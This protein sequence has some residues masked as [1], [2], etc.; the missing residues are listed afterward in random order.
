MRRTAW[1]SAGKAAVREDPIDEWLKE[2]QQP[3]DLHDLLKQITKAVLGRCA[4]R[5]MRIPATQSTIRGGNNSLSEKTKRVSRGRRQD[6]D[7]F[8]GH[9]HARHSGHLG[10]MYQV[11]VSPSLISEVTDSVMEDARERSSRCVL[12]SSERLDSDDCGAIEA[13]GKMD[14]R[15]AELI[16]EQQQD[17]IA[18]PANLWLRL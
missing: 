10:E 5:R 4:A 7:V 11:K 14:Q 6:P 9:D 8:T 17:E 13:A 3:E 1:K 15:G 16:H 18:L 12:R 2:K